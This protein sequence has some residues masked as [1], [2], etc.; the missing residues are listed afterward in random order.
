MPEMENASVAGT[1]AVVGLGTSLF[2]AFMPQMSVLRTADI[3]AENSTQVRHGAMMGS[4]TTVA[5]AGIV[6][7][8]AKSY[9]PI[10]AGIVTAVVLAVSYEYSL[11]E[12]GTG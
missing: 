1:V 2:T 12:Q 9:I 7:Y 6:G 10:L 8:W 4:I 5:F 3:N 11:R